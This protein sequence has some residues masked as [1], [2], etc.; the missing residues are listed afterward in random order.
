[1]GS[2]PA[3][4]PELGRKVTF[5]E[6]GEGHLQRLFEEEGPAAA[7][8]RKVWAEAVEAHKRDREV[9][10]EALAQ[11]A[12]CLYRDTEKNILVMRI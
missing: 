6:L 3:A 5:A 12:I 8:L 9:L 4:S 10:G 7:A 1:L 2:H 11:F